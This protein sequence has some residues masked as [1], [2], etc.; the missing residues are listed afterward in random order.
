[1]KVALDLLSDREKDELHQLVDTMVSYSLTYRYLKGDPQEKTQNLCADASED[2]PLSLDPPISDFVNFKVFFIVK[3]CY[4]DPSL[5][6]CLY[7]VTPLTRNHIRWQGYQSQYF[8]LSLAAKQILVH[9]VTIIKKCYRVGRVIN[10]NIIQ[11]LLYFVSGR[12]LCV[13][14][15]N[16]KNAYH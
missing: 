4:F 3:K 10:L 16:V 12:I 2:L 15:Q 11:I 6:F 7:A 9:E 13:P 8:A 1:M 5:T 14:F